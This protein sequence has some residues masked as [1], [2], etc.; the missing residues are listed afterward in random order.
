MQLTGVE[1]L[2][3]AEKEVLRL[4]LETSDPKDIAARIG[5]SP[6]AVDKRLRSARAKLGV[7]RTLDAAHRLAAFEGASQGTA[8]GGPGYERPAGHPSVPSETLPFDLI[9]PPSE[10]VGF[11]RRLF[12]RRGR[13]WNA[14]PASSRMFAIAAGVVLLI[15][16]AI[17]SVSLA[18][19]LSRI[20]GH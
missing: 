11:L 3:E 14:E 13:P 19:A 6:H 12:P 20:V 9:E 15:V 4:F 18:E 1:T 7:S 8:E 10:G 17:L 5:R 2:T 16:S